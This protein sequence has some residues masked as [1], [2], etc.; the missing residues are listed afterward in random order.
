MIGSDSRVVNPSR[1]ISGTIRVPGDKSISH[2]VAMLSG[3]A[4]GESVIEGFLTA[5]D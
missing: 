2:R 4:S 3:L 1:E 5:E